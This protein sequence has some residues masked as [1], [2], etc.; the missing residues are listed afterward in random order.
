MSPVVRITDSIY[1][2]L[3][4]LA[5][6]FSDTPASVI[7]RLLDAHD[8]GSETGT[9][10][11]FGE[12]VH[13]LDPDAAG[14]LRFTR[15][16][17]AHLDRQEIRRPKW[18]LISEAAHI[19]AIKRSSREIVAEVTPANIVSGS[20]RGRG[21]KYLAEADVSIQGQSATDSWESALAMARHLGSQID[22]LFEWHKKKK[23]A[24]PGERG[25]LSWSPE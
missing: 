21:F 16:L 10:S 18:N 2:R 3:Q 5:T 23:A 8:G 12:K 4:D 25:R 24:H 11:S 22:V 15:V 19:M 6:P 1:K 17:R 7:E 13:E 9:E 14:D 20:V